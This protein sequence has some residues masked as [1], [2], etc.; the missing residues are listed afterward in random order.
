MPWGFHSPSHGVGGPQQAETLPCNTPLAF[1]RS[2]R[3]LPGA[4][5]SDVSKGFQGRDPQRPWRPEQRVRKE[6]SHCFRLLKPQKVPEA[7]SRP[8]LPPKRKCSDSSSSAVKEAWVQVALGASQAV[9]GTEA[10]QAHTAPTGFLPRAQTGRWAVFHS[11]SHPGEWHPGRAQILL[12]KL[13]SW[14]P[15]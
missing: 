8:S 1:G 2:I 13:V 15:A 3:V 9:G 6:D 11:P 14:F 4:E 5:T 12:P 10:S 7:H